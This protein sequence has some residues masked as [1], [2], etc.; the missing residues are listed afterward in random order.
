LPNLDK[1]KFPTINFDAIAPSIDVKG[2]IAQQDQ[3][4]RIVDRFNQSA[5]PSKVFTDGITAKLAA[6]LEDVNKVI[7]RGIA[8]QNATFGVS[9]A[10]KFEELSQAFQKTSQQVAYF[11]Q[12]A[13]QIKDFSSIA[14][15][16]N[17]HPIFDEAIAR[18]KKAEAKGNKN[19]GRDEFFAGL[20]GDEFQAERRIVEQE[21][22]AIPGFDELPLSEQLGH[23]LEIV[24][25][26][27]GNGQ[28]DLEVAALCVLCNLFTAIL[29]Q[30][31]IYLWFL[32]SVIFY[33]ICRSGSQKQIPQMRRLL[34][35]TGAEFPLSRNQRHCDCATS[36]A[37]HLSLSPIALRGG[38]RFYSLIQLPTRS[39]WVG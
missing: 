13:D 4:Q 27:E 28:S 23:T 20:V 3:M 17:V 35:G 39:V 18:A 26:S 24:V 16:F 8:V 14:A 30:E 32:I 5:I 19:A 37:I 22:A 11:S 34:R 7:S 38:A 15:R 6:N 1:F 31:H 29:G 9:L 36:A 10:K 33:A 21:L 2:L 25:R 12:L